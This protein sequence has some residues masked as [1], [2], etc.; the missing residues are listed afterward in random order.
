MN[1]RLE[2][3]IWRRAQRICEYCLMPQDYDVLPLLLCG[4]R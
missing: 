3:L 4:N 1:L 2:R